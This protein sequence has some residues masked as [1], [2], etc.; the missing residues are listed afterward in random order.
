MRAPAARLEA[1]LAN[2][3]FMRTGPHGTRFSRPNWAGALAHQ[4]PPVPSSKARATRNANGVRGPMGPARR[5]VML[6]QSLALAALAAAHEKSET[7]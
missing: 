2:A 5:R 4:G 6:G 1:E 7:E 3:N